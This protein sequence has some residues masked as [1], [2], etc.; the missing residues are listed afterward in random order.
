MSRPALPHV[1]KRKPEPVVESRP[2]TLAE[3]RA[4]VDKETAEVRAQIMKLRAEHTER[5]LVERR[6]GRA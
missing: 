6:A 3:H 4:A 1:H 2:L 5:M